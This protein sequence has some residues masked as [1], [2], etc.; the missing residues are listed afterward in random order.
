[1]SVTGNNKIQ[2]GNL[3]VFWQR[4]GA[5]AIFVALFFVPQFPLGPLT[6]HTWVFAGG[7]LIVLIAT[8]LS[9]V[10]FVSKQRAQKKSSPMSL[11]KIS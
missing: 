11:A 1:M 5:F 6:L 3:F 7:I 9:V 8:A 10:H 2:K 4:L